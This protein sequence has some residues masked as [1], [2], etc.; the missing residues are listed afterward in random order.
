MSK[1]VKYTEFKKVVDAL[2][3]KAKDSFLTITKCKLIIYF[4]VIFILMIFFWYFVTAFCAVY[5]KY[6]TLWLIDSL[7]SLCLSM[8]F[9]FFFAMVI[10]LFRYIGLKKKKSCCY[11][12]SK[13]INIV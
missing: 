6:Q 2:W 8:V 13:V 7:K 5:P 3:A 10:V 9:P 12:F 1:I 11:C 4:I